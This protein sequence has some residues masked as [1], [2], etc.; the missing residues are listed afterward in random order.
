MKVTHRLV[1]KDETISTA[2]GGIVESSEC[3]GIRQWSDVQAIEARALVTAWPSLRTASK[4][5]SASEAAPII[6]ET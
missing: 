5:Q 1:V 3:P 2:L 6:L 4:D